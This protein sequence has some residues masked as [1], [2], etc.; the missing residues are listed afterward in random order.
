MSIKKEKKIT[1]IGAAILDVLAKTVT[2]QVFQTGSQQVEMTRLSFGGDALNEA[3]ALRRLGVDVQ[4]ISKVGKDEAGARIVDYVKGCGLSTEKIIQEDGLVTGINIVLVDENKERHF[5]TN[6]EGSL[7]KL[8]SEDIEP[9]MDEMGDIVSFASMFVSPKLDIMA[10][11]HVFK[12]I[13]SKPGS[14][15]V[16]DMTKAKNGESLDDI[17]SLLPYIDY[18]LPNEE[19]IAL[20]TGITDSRKNAELLVEAGVGCAIIKCGRR[21]CIIKTKSEYWEL[22]AFE[23]ENVE[24]TTGAG[25]CFVAGF[26]WGL[27]QGWPLK[28]CGKLACA[29][30]SCAVEQVGATEGIISAEECM[31][32]YKSLE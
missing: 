5:L 13:K 31:R 16:A 23:V 3:V 15:L 25:D 1:I 32:R 7:R 26:L 4:L 29:V 19:E 21:G 11:E 22:P 8:S 18:I 14:I 24:D 20:L 27:F 2:E 12:G 9:Y 10:M 17:K 6:P 30:A 28:E